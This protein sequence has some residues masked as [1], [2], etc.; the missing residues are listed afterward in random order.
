MP[1]IGDTNQCSPAVGRVLFCPSAQPELAGS[2]II[3]VVESRARTERVSHLAHPVKISGHWPASP[4]GY[5]AT[6]A[7]RFAAPC[8]KGECT[9][10]SGS[11]CRVAQ[12][13]VRILPASTPELPQCSLRRVCR[14]F[15]QEGTGACMR[16]S[17]VVTDD[18]R[19]E[20]ALNAA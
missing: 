19:F 9:N 12:E 14:W 20:A 18:E 10:W 3:G 4:E 2:M 13:L 5:A 11:K 8:Q 1:D 15:E 6:A 7:F 16:C 17:Q